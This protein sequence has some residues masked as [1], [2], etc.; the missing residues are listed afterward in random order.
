MAT[1]LVSRIQQLEST[2]NNAVG[3]ISQRL[4]RAEMQIAHN[5]IAQSQ[6]LLAADQAYQAQMPAQAPPNI[7]IQEALLATL[8]SAISQIMA[9][10]IEQQRQHVEE[11]NKLK[12]MIESL[13][14]AGV[15]AVHKSATA[16][17]GFKAAG[18]IQKLGDSNK[19]PFKKWVMDV[20]NLVARCEGGREALR[21]AK[22][23]NEEFVGDKFPEHM[24]GLSEDLYTLLS[25]VREGTPHDVLEAVW[26]GGELEVWRRLNKH[27][28]PKSVGRAEAIRDELMGATPANS[29][30][31]VSASLEQ[32]IVKIKE[33]SEAA[34]TPMANETKRSALRRL[35]PAKLREHLRHNVAEGVSYDTM[36]GHVIAYLDAVRA[37]EGAKMDI[38][39]VSS[40]S[41][42]DPLQ[43][44]DPWGNLSSVQGPGK[45]ARMPTK[46]SGCFLCGGPHLARNCPTG[47]S[48]GGTGGKSGP[49]PIAIKGKG[50]GKGKAQNLS[51]R[52]SKICCAFARTGKCDVEGCPYK[53]GAYKAAG[54]EPMTLG[55]MGGPGEPPL[56]L[57]TTPL[58][59][60]SDE[61][62]S[63]L[64]FYEAEGSDKD[65]QAG[66]DYVGGIFEEEEE[67]IEAES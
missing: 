39:H 63:Y 24:R 62:G 58:L 17:A 65:G 55:H 66:E 23:S 18:L 60:R 38:G 34:E 3:D 31:R 11:C 26:E 30:E 50:G 49:R 64:C 13:R 7:L 47:A 48:S 56:H 15:N 25:F 54:S 19:T 12:A 51:L 59:K 22:E 35:C 6:A 33:Y 28:S 16:L 14:T 5:M 36:R 27:H 20:T 4:A 45:G 2:A 8:E 53:H 46:P 44:Q 21:V 9:F 67:E 32:L 1:T 10:G 29:L 43:E 41:G 42:K 52:K 57:K 37:E 40:R 61:Y